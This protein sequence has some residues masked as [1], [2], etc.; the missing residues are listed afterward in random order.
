MPSSAAATFT[1]RC[2]S[3]PPVTGREVSTIVTAIPAFHCWVRDGTAA[4]SGTVD[5]P[6]RA[7]RSATLNRRHHHLGPGRRIVLKTALTVSRF[8]SQTRPRRAERNPHQPSAGGY[9]TAPPTSSMPTRSRR[10]WSWLRVSA[11]CSV[12]RAIC[13]AWMVIPPRDATEAH[14]RQMGIELDIVFDVD[15]GELVR[16]HHVIGRGIDLGRTV[17]VPRWM[18]DSEAEREKRWADTG[19][20]NFGSFRKVLS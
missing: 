17:D 10:G 16:G 5:R 20:A 13:Q 6:V 4:S 8:S 18:A 7:G 2:V 3:T 14:L 9:Q 19:P 1:S 11:A 12:R 15:L